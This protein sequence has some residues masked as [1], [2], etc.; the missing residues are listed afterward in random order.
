MESVLNEVMIY[1]R[2][3]DATL[4]RLVRLYERAAQDRIFASFEI[5]SA[6]LLEFQQAHPDPFCEYPDP[7]ERIRFWDEHLKI[8]AALED[9]SVPSAYMSEFDQGLYGGLLGGE[10]RFMAH[11]ENGWV[12]SM[13]PP[14]LR[15]WSG[16]DALEFNCS[17]PWWETYLR[18][19]RI[20]REGAAGKFGISHFILINGLNFAFELVGASE[21][22][23]SL[24][25]NPESIRKA[26]DLA[27]RVNVA[28]QTAFFESTDSC[29]GGTFSNMVQWIPGRIVSESV[30]PFHMTSVRCFE[31][32]GREP[33][34]RVFDHF[35]GGV[36]HL[37]ANGRHLLEAVNTLRGLKA[38]HLG[39]DR[40]FPAAIEVV[41]E[42]R[43]R[44]GDLPLLLF[45][46]YPVFEEKLRK[47]ELPGG[48]FYKVTGCPDADTANRMMESVRG[49]RV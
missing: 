13:V 37:H 3:A 8:R 32:W 1:K 42:M 22:Y 40:G 39:D 28:V 6:A 34:Q 15:D 41:P 43:R 17:G 11:P 44:S 33:A 2:N 31:E 10:V 30:D 48:V 18:Q 27:L 46:E 35:D 45:V 36:L 38:I 9:D 16:M 12:S 25:E 47:H 20:F 5:P 26:L 23:L 21:T 14:L 4:E 49:Y 24:T 7:H 19:L 29:R